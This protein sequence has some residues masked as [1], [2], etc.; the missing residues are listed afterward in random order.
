M[1]EE[2]TAGAYT[3]HSEDLPQVDMWQAPT[4]STSH[5]ALTALF[6]PKTLNQVSSPV[7]HQG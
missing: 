1:I 4:R 2:A 6:S 7:A 5:A 3:A